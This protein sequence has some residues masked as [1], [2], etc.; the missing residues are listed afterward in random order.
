MKNQKSF[1]G[2]MLLSSLFYGCSNH[3]IEKT[4][5]LNEIKLATSP[6]RVSL[7]VLGQ[8]DEQL[9]DANNSSSKSKLDPC[10]AKIRTGMCTLTQTPNLAK[11][12][13]LDKS[14]NLIKNLNDEVTNDANISDSLINK[15]AIIFGKT[16]TATRKYNKKTKKH[17]TESK[18]DQ[19]VLNKLREDLISEIGS[20]NFKLNSKTR[21]FR[22]S[23]IKNSSA[24]ATIQNVNLENVVKTA[25]ANVGKNIEVVH[26]GN[27]LGKEY[28]ISG[29]IT[30]FD[31]VFGHRSGQRANAYGG[32]GKG[33][34]DIGMN[35][36][37]E[38]EKI[39][40]TLDLFISKQTDANATLKILSK[41]TSSNTLT[42]KKNSTNNG[43]SLSIMGMGVNFTDNISV[44]DPLGYGT[45]LL[46][47]KSLVELL[48]KMNDLDPRAFEVKK[49]DFQDF[50]WNEHLDEIYKINDTDDEKTK[51]TKKAKHDKIKKAFLS[52]LNSENQQKVLEICGYS[53]NDNYN[54][55]NLRK[56]MD[57]VPENLINKKSKL[58][59]SY[60]QGVKNVSK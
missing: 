25:L 53:N 26:G 6:Y 39:E 15:V 40:I 35:N 44:S 48:A 9:G 17:Y 10:I 33:E 12:Y 7:S 8:I 18:I 46:V 60:N 51:N 38:D 45:R 24:D 3:K 19:K 22:V 59:A 20:N 23:S 36:S 58:E 52:Q 4:T 28:L 29:S 14:E 56:L 50:S 13:K 54:I 30:G 32:Q 43:F 2:I 41:V 11:V 57:I 27:S 37:D 21:F 49:S 55:S 1:V 16:P 47:E 31:K 5:E 34:F 42:L